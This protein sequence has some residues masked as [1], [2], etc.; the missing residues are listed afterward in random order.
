MA[1]VDSQLPTL[2]L[3]LLHFILQ[4]GTSQDLEC[5]PGVHSRLHP[6]ILR[7]KPNG[8]WIRSRTPSWAHWRTSNSCPQTSVGN[9]ENLFY[10]CRSV[11]VWLECNGKK[12]KRWKT[13]VFGSSLRCLRFWCIG[14]WISLN[15]TY[16]VTFQFYFC[17]G[18][19]V[20]SGDKIRVVSVLRVLGG[21]LGEAGEEEEC[22]KCF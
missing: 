17:Q 5:T 18:R 3:S 11:C 12:K 21:K 4:W 9:R 8:R 7:S 6:C 19:L 1:A 2:A 16:A 10:M 15:S 14:G 22:L 13:Y 20:E